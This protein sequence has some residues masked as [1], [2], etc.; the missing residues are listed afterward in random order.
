MS[1]AAS[2]ISLLLVLMRTPNDTR[3][4]SFFKLNEKYFSKF[5]SFASVENSYIVVFPLLDILIGITNHTC[6]W[7]IQLD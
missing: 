6:P 5:V 3:V 1:L 7:H 2:Y 4:E